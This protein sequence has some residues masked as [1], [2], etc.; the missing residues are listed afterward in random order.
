MST[1]TMERIIAVCCVV[2]LICLIGRFIDKSIYFK[3]FGDT[4][5]FLG[6]LLNTITKK[7][8]GQKYKFSMFLTFALGLVWV[9]DLY[10][11]IQYIWQ[12]FLN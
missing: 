9:G 6:C 2:L 3:F 1:K 11:F 7:R 10:D 8:E 12:T 5:L 4:A